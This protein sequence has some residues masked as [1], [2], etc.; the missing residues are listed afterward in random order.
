MS[1]KSSIVFHDWIVMSQAYQ[2]KFSI[3]KIN[4]NKHSIDASLY[5]VTKCVTHVHI[6]AYRFVLKNE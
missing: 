6:V 5:F 3:Y 4:Q 2:M 1:N